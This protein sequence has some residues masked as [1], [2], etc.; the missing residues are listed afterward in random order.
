MSRAGPKRPGGPGSSADPAWAPNATGG[1]GGLPVP[2]SVFHGLGLA[3]AV[4]LGP[5]VVVAGVAALGADLRP[6]L[7]EVV[8]AGQA[9]LMTLA[10]VLAWLGRSRRLSW[11]LLGPARPRPARDIATGVLLAVPGAGL[12]IAAGAAARAAVGEAGV[13]ESL[14]A[15]ARAPLAVAAA[16]VV[17]VIVSPVL[18]ELVHRGVLFQALRRIMPGPLAV[19]VSGVVFALAQP[20]GTGVTDLV[21]LT[22][23][24]GYLAAVFL[25]TGSLLVVIVAHGG[26]N[27]LALAARVAVG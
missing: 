8:V 11:R 22:V 14:D 12:A 4:L 21:A 16:A 6:P 2:W 25:R 3:L 19:G 5:V 20:G 23:L 10:G 15:S 13:I 1:D 9:M 7:T 18:L 24:G 26:V 27:A 17:L